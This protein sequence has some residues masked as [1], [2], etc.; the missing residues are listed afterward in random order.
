MAKLEDIKREI[1]GLS[2][3]EAFKLAEWLDV[4]A[5][6]HWDRQIEADAKSGTLDTLGGHVL[7]DHRAGLTR[8]LRNPTR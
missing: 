1:A 4:Y 2:V 3:A 6:E 7:A 8:P 5:N